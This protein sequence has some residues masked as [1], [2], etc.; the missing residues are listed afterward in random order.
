MKEAAHPPGRCAAFQASS[1]THPCSEV[2][3]VLFR[4]TAVSG[5]PLDV[6]VELSRPVRLRYESSVPEGASH[7]LTSTQCIR[8]AKGVSRMNVSYIYEYTLAWRGRCHGK[9]SKLLFEVSL[10]PWPLLI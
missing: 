5:S 9:E 4:T 7:L 8:E 2:Q 6:G 1:D 3:S 10:G